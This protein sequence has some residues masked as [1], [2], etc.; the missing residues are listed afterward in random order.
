[1]SD[2]KNI[3]TDYQV[4]N[5]NETDLSDS[6]IDLFQI[7]MDK[8]VQV[9]KKDANAFVLST[10]NKNGF[11]SSRVVLLRG[12]DQGSFCFFTNYNSNKASNMEEN[13]QVAM[14]F[15]WP[16][17]ERQIRIEGTIERTSSEYSDDYF[18]SRPYSSKI[19]AWASDQSSVIKTRTELEENV[20]FYE[21][22][23][24]VDVPRPDFWGGYKIIPSAIEFWQGRSNRLHDRFVYN[25]EKND[26][27]IDRLSP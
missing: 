10:I 3:R 4:G 9:V 12:L 26:W 23:F 2:L 18:Q 13:K 1:M 20:S 14:N 8:A 27:K 16:D 17:L 22:K 24:P 11:P 15:F 21:N 19:G 7:W 25:Q 5:L 6:P